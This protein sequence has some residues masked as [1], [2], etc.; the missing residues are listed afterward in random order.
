[1]GPEMM[2]DLKKQ[3]E[4]FGTDVRFGMVTK[5]ELNKIP[6]AGHILTIDENVQI[7]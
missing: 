5:T 6:G 3:A 1:M 4:R 7:Q 2:E